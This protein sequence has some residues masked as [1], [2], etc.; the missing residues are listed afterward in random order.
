MTH[1]HQQQHGIK[2]PK[3]NANENFNIENEHLIWSLLPT[4]STEPLP[5]L[6]LSSS[7]KNSNDEKWNK[8]FEEFLV[9]LFIGRIK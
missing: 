2:D 4:A 6:A 3:Q 9:S 7:T 8:R 1:H 5:S